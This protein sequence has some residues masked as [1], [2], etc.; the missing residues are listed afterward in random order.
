VKSPQRWISAGLTFVACALL[1]A[2]VVAQTPWTVTVTPTLNP[3]PVGLCAA[4]QLTVLD[5]SGK[6][7]PRNPLGFRVTIAD[8]DIVVSGASVAANRV[9]ASHWQACACQGASTGSTGTIIASYPARSLAANARVPG[10]AVQRTATFGVAAPKGGV[11]P[12]ACTAAAGSNVAPAPQAPPATTTA[13]PAA[14][15]LAVALPPAAPPT[16]T[17]ASAPSAAA[18]PG[19]SGLPAGAIGTTAGR[20]PPYVPAPL[21]VTLALSASGAWYEPGPLI[22]SLALSGHGSWYEPAPSTHTFDLSATGRWIERTQTPIDL[23]QP[24][25]PQP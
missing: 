17:P 4:I 12:P 8:F 25:P 23:L 20:T 9:D 1:P 21:I 16:R 2:S 13:P 3:L 24:A 10:V 19:T 7:V 6:D 22:S 15:P 14:P 18:R 5:A 11:N